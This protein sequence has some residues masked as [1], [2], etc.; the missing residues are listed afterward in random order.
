[1]G[2]VHSGGIMLYALCPIGGAAGIH[3]E[4]SSLR[5]NEGPL[6]YSYAPRRHSLRPLVQVKSSA[7]NLK[8]SATDFY[9][10]KSEVWVLSP[11]WQN[12][13]HLIIVILLIIDNICSGF[14]ISFFIDT[15]VRDM[16][17]DRTNGDYRG[18]DV[19][20]MYNNI[21]NY[22]SWPDPRERSLT[23][24][25]SFKYYFSNSDRAH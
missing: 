17:K 24:N 5:L 9:I 6:S 20:Q 15:I 14:S 19:F 12:Q 13:V 10:W 4:G 25:L 11:R 8:L 23:D 21:N 3:N 2:I 16:T 7:G 18:V 22:N 1:M